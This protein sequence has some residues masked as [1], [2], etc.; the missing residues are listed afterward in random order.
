MEKS[1]SNS[2][3]NRAVGNESGYSS[4]NESDQV[5]THKEVS[6][7]AILLLHLDVMVFAV[8]SQPHS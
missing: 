4:S 3:V 8:G 7:R 5:D 1:D 6:I 2:K